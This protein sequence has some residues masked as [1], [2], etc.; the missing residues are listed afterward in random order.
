MRRKMQKLNILADVR[1]ICRGRAPR[2]FGG[3]LAQ[4]EQLSTKLLDDEFDH[5]DSFMKAMAHFFFHRTQCLLFT[6]K[7]GFQEFL[8]TT[9]VA[10]GPLPVKPARKG[11]ST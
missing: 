9:G 8:S 1:G 3:N 6:R 2:E 11:P 7:L 4:P 10:S 5:P